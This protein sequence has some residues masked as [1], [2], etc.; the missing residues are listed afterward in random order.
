MTA[1]IDSD[2]DATKLWHMRFGHAGEKSM[3][4]LAKQNLL[5]SAKTCKMKFYEHCVL[6][7]KIKVKFG[8]AFTLLKG[9]LIMCIQM[10]G[11]SR[12]LHLLEENTILSPFL[13][14]TLGE[15]GCTPCRIKVKS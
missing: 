4:T 12:R 11:V 6:S 7:K 9:F 10:F 15:I 13:K 8:T 5:K 1:S 2:D 14:I 3:Q